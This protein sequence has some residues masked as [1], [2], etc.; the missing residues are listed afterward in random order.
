MKRSI[1]YIVNILA[2]LLFAAGLSLIYTETPSGNGITWV[3]ADSYEDSPQ[4]SGMVNSDISRIKRLAELKSAFEDDTG[5]VDNRALVV[6]AETD[7][8]QMN[9]MLKDLESIAAK[10]GCTMDSETHRINMSNDRDADFSDYK[11]R[12]IHKFYDPDYL[13]SLPVGPGRGVMNVSELSI[14]VMLAVAELYDLENSYEGF[15]GNF[16]FTITYPGALRGEDYIS[17]EN[18]TLSD[19]DILRMNK[20]IS[21]TGNEP[22][23]TNIIPSPSSAS[24]GRYLLNNSDIESY[25][26]VV[27]IDTTYPYND[28][29]KMAAQSFEGD[30]ENIYKAIVLMAAGLLLAII[31]FIP[32]IRYA[33]TYRKERT[34]DREAAFSFDRIPLEAVI[35]VSGLMSVICFEAFTHYFFRLIQIIFPAEQW[36]YWRSV[37]KGLIGYVSIIVILR[38]LVSRWKRD[39]LLE[40]SVVLRAF[41]GIHEALTKL[42]VS[43]RLL[44]QYVVF[45]AIN[46]L[47]IIA[48]QWLFFNR[49]VHGWLIPVFAGVIIVLA[50][51]DCF[52]FA[53]IFREEKQRRE[54]A[55]ALRHISGGETDYE[56]NEA[57]FTGVQLESAK[58]INHIS[59]GLRE[60]LNEQVKS[61]RL[62]ADLITNVSHDIRTPLTS[63]INYVDLLKRENISDAKVAEYIDVLDKKSA[64]LKNLTDDLLEA[65]KASSGSIKMDLQKIDFSALAMQAGGEFDEKFAARRLELCLTLPD[66]PAFIYAD[67]RH[68]WR[69]LENLYNNA[70]K[71]ALEGTR[72]Y[73]DVEEAAEEEAY[74]FVLKNVSQNKLNVSPEELT[75]RFVR[76]DVSR[77]TEGSGLGL[78]IATSLAKL[79]NG[80]VRI[81]IDGDLYKAIVTIPKYQEAPQE[82]VTEA[83]DSSGDSLNAETDG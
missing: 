17:F 65:S 2:V 25:K 33:D 82:A 76:G 16:Y 23:N 47:M 28:K 48:A 64:R 51:F 72:V 41:A 8:G 42:D 61:E 63:I 56:V 45:V 38:C 50:V 70:A 10:N 14:E 15:S 53:C 36:V 9:Y 66:Q 37:V 6:T 12:I 46:A 13:D 62:Q 57:D 19:D 20:Y 22:V 78:N 75:E 59:I 83:G 55:S 3:N 81:V 29:Y 7:N 68:L 71:Y 77:S 73:A 30:V 52:A 44:F 26:L 18:T 43:G 24:I 74:R 21:V 39:C 4:F 67:G 49:N 34:S 11:I 5:D 58:S 69:V 79:M 40:S 27:G 32:I 31:T 60:A 35:I 54:L 80:S 1:L